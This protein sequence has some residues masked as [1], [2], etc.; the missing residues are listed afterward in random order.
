MNVGMNMM[1][2][3]AGVSV[4]M[5]SIRDWNM[6]KRVRAD[7]AA[8]L[9]MIKVVCR[10]NIESDSSVDNQFDIQNAVKIWIKRETKK[11]IKSIDQFCLPTEYTHSRFLEI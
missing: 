9:K 11:I 10:T 5:P 7:I 8:M 3:I 2:T 6:T 1:Y 4:V